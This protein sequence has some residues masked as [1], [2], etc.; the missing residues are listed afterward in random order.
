MDGSAG[1]FVY[2]LRKVGIRL[3]Q[4]FKRFLLIK[5][6]LTLRKGDR[7]VSVHPGR[8]LRVTY[9]IDFD[10]PLL[11]EQT[12]VLEFSGQEYVREIS[13][14]RTF[15]FLKDVGTLRNNGF[16]R[17]GSL[18]NAIVLDDCA[19]LNA[20]GLRYEDEFVRHKI[21]DFVGDLYL[22]G[23]PVIGHFIVHKSGHTLNQSLLTELLQ[24]KDFWKTVRFPS[25]RACEARQI[26]V[27]TFGLPQVATA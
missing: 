27:P 8:E 24:R 26:A 14:A 6:P 18:E 20:E 9:T 12:F 5:K 23:M 16:A 11:S 4:E 2:L 21:L 7:E 13:R 17:G 1:P 10:H 19:V 15:G 22:V 3:Q 25:E